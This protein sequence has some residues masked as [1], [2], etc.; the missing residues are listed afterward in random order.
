MVV[1]PELASTFK[2]AG[3]RH[4]HPLARHPA[5]LGHR[6]PPDSRETIRSPRRA[7]TFRSPDTSRP[8]S[9]AGTSPPPR[10]RTGSRTAPLAHGTHSKKLPDGGDLDTRTLAPQ[11]DKL[12]A[13]LEAARRRGEIRRDPEARDL[14][15]EV[16]DELSEGE[17]GLA[18]AIL[19]RSEAQA[20]RLSL[21]YAL[22][23]GASSIQHAHL[24]AALELWHYSARSSA[25]CSA[26]RPETPTP[27]RSSRH[28]DARTATGSPEPRSRRC[29]GATQAQHGSTAH[30]EPFSPGTRSPSGRREPE[31]A[32]SNGGLV[33]LIRIVRVRRTGQ[34]LPRRSSTTVL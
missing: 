15:H 21:V 18:G 14:W 7:P 16:Y 32:R 5:G 23:E 27:T 12:R 20:T 24:K 33:R 28:Y 9:C 19:A 34:S 6:H 11:V 29:L 4:E 1:E 8:T 3:A 10:P 2:V 30:S 13:A 22:A 25:T 17:P 31:A 26:T